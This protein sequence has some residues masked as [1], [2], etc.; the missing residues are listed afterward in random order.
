MKE[1]KILETYVCEIR[2]RE[3]HNGN[4]SKCGS[5]KLNGK[6][7]VLRAGWIC[8]SDSQYCGEVAMIPNSMFSTDELMKYNI[9]WLASGDVNIICRLRDTGHEKLEPMSNHNTK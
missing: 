2:I 4:V 9:A 7:L 5:E 3:I 8:E 6:R 1:I